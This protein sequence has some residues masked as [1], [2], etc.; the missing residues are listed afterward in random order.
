MLSSTASPA[1]PRSQVLPVLALTYNAFA[2]GLSWWPFRYLQAQGLHPLWA[3]CACYGLAV[4]LIWRWRPAAWQQLWS[5]PALWVVMLASGLT[6]ASFNWA[7]T[8]GDVVRVVL[9]FYLMPLWSVLLAR[10]LLHERFTVSGLFRIGLALAGAAVVLKPEGVPFPLPSGRADWL[11]LLGG[12][13]FALNSVMLRRLGSR[14]REEGRAAA[15]LFGCVV[16]AGSLALVLGP[17]RGIALPPAPQLAWVALATGL[18][19]A[20]MCSNMAYQFG[21]ARLPANVTSVVMLTEVVFASVSS[22]AWGGETLTAQTLLGGS[23]IVAAALLAAV[24]PARW[25][26]RRAP[27][28]EGAARPPTRDTRG[29]SR[30]VFQGPKRPEGGRCGDSS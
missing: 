10:V 2:W 18:A 29:Y 4:L 16:I 22:V 14:T 30:R 17:Q 3:T 20:F 9:L 15:M 7:V 19:L 13:A 11:A 6:N 8:V 12:F 5:A 28:F 21:A 23:M 25:G 26:T 1:A 24:G 27:P